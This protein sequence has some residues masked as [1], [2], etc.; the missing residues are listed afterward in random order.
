MIQGTPEY[1]S[2]IGNYEPPS[3]AQLAASAKYYPPLDTDPDNVVTRYGDFKFDGVWET[4]NA[5]TFD[6]RF[7]ANSQSVVDIN[8]E[9]ATY[10][11]GAYKI[12]IARARYYA[13]VHYSGVD[14]TLG[15]SVLSNLL[16]PAIQAHRGFDT[17]YQGDQL[18]NTNN[19]YSVDNNKWKNDF[20]FGEVRN[21]NV[22]NSS[23]TTVGS[24]YWNQLTLMNGYGR[25]WGSERTSFYS[26]MNTEAIG[27]SKPD[28]TFNNLTNYSGSYGKGSSGNE[29]T[30]LPS[31]FN[32]AIEIEYPDSFNAISIRVYYAPIGSNYDWADDNTH[33]DSITAA[34]TNGQYNGGNGGAVFQYMSLI[35]INDDGTETLYRR[36]WYTARW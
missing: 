10:G 3:Q 25:T 7:V 22:N 14:S 34:S 11:N 33:N 13:R 2:N 29:W 36:C 35:S 6:T 32:Y 21:S 31:S 5:F 30:T 23:T 28:V 1:L 9:G 20:Y 27:T 18:T 15:P 4:N 26:D 12:R 24:P 8:Q 17:N 16:R 19:Y